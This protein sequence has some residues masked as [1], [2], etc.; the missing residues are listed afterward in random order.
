MQLVIVQKHI[1]INYDTT[2]SEEYGE[3]LSWNSHVYFERLKGQYFEEKLY[4]KLITRKSHREIKLFID[5][6]NLIE[7]FQLSD[8]Q[9]FGDMHNDLRY[10]FNLFIK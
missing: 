9:N 2:G 4:Q 7:F 1:K 3:L 8:Q 6:Q 10:L 5:L